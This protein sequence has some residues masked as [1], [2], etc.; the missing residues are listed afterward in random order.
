MDGDGGLRL[1]P[2][3]PS[4]VSYVY[5]LDDPVT[6]VV[7]FAVVD[8]LE[9]PLHQTSV[10]QR[11]DVV[12]FT[13]QPLASALLVC[14]IPR[15]ELFAA[16]D[17]DDTDWHVK[18]TEVDPQ[19]RSTRI[20]GGCVR[21]SHAGDLGSPAPV[22]PGEVCRYDIELDACAHE[23]SVGV[24]VRVSI[25]SSDFPWFARGLNRFGG[26][27]DLAD[28][29]QATNTIAC[30]SP[31]SRLLLPAAHGASPGEPS[32]EPAP[33]WRRSRVAQSGGLH[34]R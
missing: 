3:L 12:T 28:S 6:T 1:A 13:S 5:D 25:T 23:F 27:C 11:T 9:P 29:R 34:V 30:G 24:R 31:A 15:V 17:G 26:I 33:V 7:D 4:R 8:A 16:T 20:A 2:G 22:A 19:G 14:G 18:L 32:A 10:E 21:A